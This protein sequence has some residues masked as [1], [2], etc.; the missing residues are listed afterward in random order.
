MPCSVST[1]RSS[2][3]TGGFPASGS[4]TGFT[5]K[6]TIAPGRNLRLTV[7]SFPGRSGSFVL[8]GRSQSQSLCPFHQRARSEAPLLH[9]NYPVSTLLRASPPP[10]RPGLALAGCPLR[11]PPL[12]SSVSRASCVFLRYMPS[13]LPRWN[14]RV[15]LSHLFPCNTGLPRVSVRS[16]STTSVSRPHRAF[17]C[18]TAC[19]FAGSPSDPFHRRLRRICCLLRRFDCYWASDPSQ[20]GLP[21]ARIHTHSRRTDT[22]L[23]Y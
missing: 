23:N 18:V 2:N 12:S 22:R 20:A 19:I 3:R 1:S 11:L 9:R 10:T 7:Q 6:P 8:L 16:A 14:C 4:P 17:T 5:V 15:R 21:P 13:S